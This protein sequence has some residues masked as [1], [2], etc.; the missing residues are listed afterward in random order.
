MEVVMFIRKIK[1]YI[2]IGLFALGAVLGVAC[3]RPSLQE[4]QQ[5][6]FDELTTEIFTHEVQSDTLSLNYTL[7]RPEDFGII[8]EETTLGEYSIDYMKEEL[9]LTE[10]YLDD[11]KKL[12]YNELTDTRN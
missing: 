1:L 7:A 5:D 12:D 10:Q 11:L 2:L 9:L 8:H 6:L 3:D 4:S